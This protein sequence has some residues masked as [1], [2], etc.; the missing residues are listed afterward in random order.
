[1]QESRLP[2]STGS[3]LTS[4]QGLTFSRGAKGTEGVRAV[5]RGT[6]VPKEGG[7][8]AQRGSGTGILTAVRRIQ[9]GK[10]KALAQGFTQVK[11][12]FKSR[13]APIPRLLRTL[14]GPSIFSEQQYAPLHQGV[15]NPGEEK[16][17]QQQSSSNPMMKH[18]CGQG[19]CPR[20]GQGILLLSR[21][22]R[23]SWKDG[24]CLLSR[25]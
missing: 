12:K 18:P 3:A 21:Q 25:K 16:V 24:L 1:M 4:R 20:D 8:G 5:L 19:R 9:I 2:D 11:L 13:W 14:P 10:S 15:Y 17:T 23:L 22:V 7:S 6:H